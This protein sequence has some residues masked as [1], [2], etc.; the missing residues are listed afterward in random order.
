M[1][2]RILEN[3]EVVL[4][5]DGTMIVAGPLAMVDFSKFEDREYAA[6]ACYAKR[7]EC[8]QC[9]DPIQLHTKEKSSRLANSSARAERIELIDKG[10]WIYAKCPT[11]G[12]VWT[13]TENHKAECL[14]KDIT[15]TYNTQPSTILEEMRK[16]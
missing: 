14:R 8:P 7:G 13:M 1:E 6:R 9:G 10:W 16:R 12:D 5:S 15:A 2:E 3:G 11:C 4:N